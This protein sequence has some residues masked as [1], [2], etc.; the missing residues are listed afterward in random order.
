M[1]KGD[2]VREQQAGEGRQGRA[3]YK[4]RGEWQRRS[5]QVTA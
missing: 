2:E 3:K 1:G 5:D 4:E